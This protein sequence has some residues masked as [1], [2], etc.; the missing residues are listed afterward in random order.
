MTKSEF[1]TQL[2]TDHGYVEYSAEPNTF[3][4]LVPTTTN[5][6]TND[7]PPQFALTVHSLTVHGELWEAFSINLVGESTIN[8]WA[9]L[10][11]YS[12][13][14]DSIDK[15]GELEQSLQLAWEVINDN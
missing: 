9:N 7:K 8:E 4:K 1:T 3:Y 6:Q 15:L 2:L 5:C 11:Y 10:S 13:L 14:L 12:V